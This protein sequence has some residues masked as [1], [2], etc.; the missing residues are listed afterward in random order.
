MT[1]SRDNQIAIADMALRLLARGICAAAML[2]KRIAAD[3][4]AL[5]NGFSF[6]VCAGLGEH[7]PAVKLLTENGRFVRVAT[8]TDD[9]NVTI[10]FKDVT[11]LLPVIIGRKSVETAFAQ[12]RMLVW[13]NVNQA[14]MLVR[15]I[16]IAET[17]LF[18]KPMI[19]KAMRRVP[20]KQVP[21]L[22]VYLTL[23]FFGVRKPL[24]AP[25]AEAKPEDA[26]TVLETEREPE[27]R[28]EAAK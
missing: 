3:V 13:G 21:S 1:I 19:K 27:E 17:Y 16:G 14:V 28:L 20:K 2:D 26:E 8:G 18:P 15:I 9:T 12:H 4:S 25:T 11:G 6:A 24:A 22:F 10:R 23:P 5:G 7:A